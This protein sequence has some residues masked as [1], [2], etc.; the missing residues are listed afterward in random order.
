MPSPVTEQIGGLA[1]NLSFGLYLLLFVPQLWLNLRRQSTVGFSLV[2]QILLLTAMNADLVYGWGT[3]LPWQYRTVSVTGLSLL[4]LQQ[5]QFCWTQ[6][7][8][9]VLGLTF[10]LLILTVSALWI[11]SQL[12]ALPSSLAVGCGALANI[13]WLSAALPQLLLNWRLG[14]ARGLS[15]GYVSIA[16]TCNLLDTLSAWTLGWAWPSR[17]GAPLATSLKALLLWQC[18]KSPASNKEPISGAED[19]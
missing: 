12:S 16:L 13:C 1:L 7:T 5:L 19:K 10:A 18:L 15:L 14:Q 4:W 17:L 6:R 2:T 8:L 3:E 9:R 11:T